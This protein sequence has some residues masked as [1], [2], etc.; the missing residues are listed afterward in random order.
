MK[1][2][3]RTTIFVEHF[4]RRA[5]TRIKLLFREKF[6]VFKKNPYDS[7]LNNHPLKYGLRGLRSWSLTDDSGQDDFRV[8]YKP[9]KNGDCSFV[10][11][12]THTQIYRAW[13]K[14]DTYWIK[15]Q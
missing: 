11:F 4:N 12:G 6:E 15:E 1:T 10:D 2:I 7:S 5:N 9:E 8:L 14:T 13:I 3:S